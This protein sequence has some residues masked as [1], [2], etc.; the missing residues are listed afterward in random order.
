MVWVVQGTLAK[1]AR[2]GYPDYDVPRHTA[3]VWVQSVDN[4]GIAS[5]ICLL[6]LGELH[7]YYSDASE[8]YNLLDLYRTNGFKVLHYPVEDDMSP[9]VSGGDLFA[10]LQW[11]TDLP[12]PILVHC[13]A[14]VMRT[15]EVVI[16]LKNSLPRI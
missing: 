7:D 16:R 13:S 2:P 9:P 11:A 12:R 10:I 8:G 15:G 6:T 3:L 4:Q 14:G 5:I 1:S